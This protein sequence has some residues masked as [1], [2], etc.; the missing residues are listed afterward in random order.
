MKDRKLRTALKDAGIIYDDGNIEFVCH[1]FHSSP[2]KIDLLLDY[3][4]LQVEG[5]MRIVKNDK[6]AK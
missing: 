5:G 3:L 4:G 2:E 1:S 6:E